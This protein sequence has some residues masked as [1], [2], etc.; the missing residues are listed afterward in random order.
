MPRSTRPQPGRP[1]PRGTWARVPRVGARPVRSQQSEDACGV[2]C[3]EMLLEDR[4][5]LVS[6]LELA[7]D[8]ALPVDAGR[9]A[10]RMNAVSPL[11]WRGGAL[12]IDAPTWAMVEEIGL[13][14]GTWAALLEPQGPWR[15]GHWVVVDGVSDEGLVLVRDPIGEAYGIPLSEFLGLW[16]FAVLVREGSR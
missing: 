5:I 9:L 6:Q 4:G 15:T 10:R 12:N 16:H 8:L 11:N 1:F 13:V 2:A 14:H 7:A 3:A